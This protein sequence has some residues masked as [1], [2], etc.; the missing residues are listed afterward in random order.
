MFYLRG[1]KLKISASDSP[2]VYEKTVPSPTGNQTFVEGKR[3]P[4]PK[5]PKGSSPDRYFGK[6]G[7]LKVNNAKIFI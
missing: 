4:K 1:A 7:P 5:G 3:T 2:G 6:S